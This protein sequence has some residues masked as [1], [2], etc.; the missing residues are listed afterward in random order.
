LAVTACAAAAL[1]V[2]VLMLLLVVAVL[3]GSVRWPRRSQEATTECSNL[4]PPVAA[5]RAQMVHGSRNAP[6]VASSEDEVEAAA[7]VAV[8]LAHRR[9]PATMTSAVQAASFACTVAG[10]KGAREVAHRDG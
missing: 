8:V 2:V 4:C 3:A 9:A 1:L 6:P 5:M 7:G 10:R